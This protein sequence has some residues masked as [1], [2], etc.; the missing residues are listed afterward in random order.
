MLAPKALRKQGDAW[1]CMPDTVFYLAED[2]NIKDIQPLTKYIYL[3]TF[4]LFI[5]EEAGIFPQSSGHP[6][7]TS[8]TQKYFMHFREP[9]FLAKCLLQSNLSPH[10][11][12]SCRLQHSPSA[13]PETSTAEVEGSI[14]LHWIDFFCLSSAKSNIE[15]S[16]PNAKCFPFPTR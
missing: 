14:S 2:L 15:S 6:A 8:D 11:S 4:F 13:P 16:D 9:L 1:H 12:Y 7:I 5:A 3:F 10:R